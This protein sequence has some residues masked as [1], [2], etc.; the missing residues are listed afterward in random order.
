VAD[1]PTDK[2]QARRAAAKRP[3][4]GRP[5]AGKIAAKAKPKPKSYS[6]SMGP[7]PL[8]DD[9][10]QALSELQQV[11]G[12]PVWMLIQCGT[13]RADSLEMPVLTRFLDARAELAADGHVA[14]VID[15]PGGQGDVAY[16]TARILQRDGGFT[17]VI[18]RYAKS[19]ATLLSLG[20]E[21]AIMGGDAEIGP[22]DAQLW[23]HEREE[24]GS[25][26]NE[27]AAL[28]QLHAVA[29]AHLDA[30]M[31]TMVGGTRKKTDVLLPIAAKFVSDMMRP[32]LE[33]ID[34]VH[35]AK[36]ARILAVAEEYA[37][38]LLAHTGMP[39]HRARA[40]ADTLVN[41]YPEHGFV[42]DR[43]EVEDRGLLPLD[44]PADEVRDAVARVEESL[45]RHQLTAFGKLQE[46]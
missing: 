45:W 22:L 3:T 40:I 1:V 6:A 16:Q 41:R 10:G 44:E 21:R 39:P 27:V 12:L 7:A 25:A 18:P 29:L 33:K 42:I 17:V 46:S 35:Y 5:S 23:D 14:L 11:L 43:Q 20:A 24:P 31:V 28:D 32:M 9:F 37:V 26:L 15:S 4:N 36:Q 30:T 34:A 8:P 2:K 13:S 38:R 19:A